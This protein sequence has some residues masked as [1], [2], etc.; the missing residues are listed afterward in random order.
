MLSANFS[1]PFFHHF[2]YFATPRNTK[3]F[4]HQWH[5]VIDVAPTILEAVNVKPPLKARFF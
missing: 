2:H 3:K 4:R 1:L 5:H